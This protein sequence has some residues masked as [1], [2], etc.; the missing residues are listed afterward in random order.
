MYFLYMS[1]EKFSF[2]VL[3]SPVQWVITVNNFRFLSNILETMS[4][5]YMYYISLERS[6]YNVSTPFCCFKIHTEMA[7]L[8]LRCHIHCYPCIY[9]ILLQILS[10]NMDLFKS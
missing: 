6:F 5:A 1:Y 2:C 7:K 10:L 9:H 8:K 4:T 3:W